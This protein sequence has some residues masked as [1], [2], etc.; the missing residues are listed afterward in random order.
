[1]DLLRVKLLTGIYMSLAHVLNSIHAIHKILL[2]ISWLI[3][4]IYFVI[5]K[6]I[7]GYTHQASEG[8]CNE[9]SWFLP[10]VS[11]MRL[12]NKF[13]LRLFITFGLRYYCYFF[14]IV[15]TIFNFV[16]LIFSYINRR[17]G[18]CSFCFKA[19]WSP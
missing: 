6:I 2:E 12:C 15:T 8:I 13:K 11:H 16:K 14:D 7:I 5:F 3:L 10:W 18:S 9:D 1:M 19:A 4:N 17:T